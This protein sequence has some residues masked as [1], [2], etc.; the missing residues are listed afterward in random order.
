MAPH[1]T[2]TGKEVRRHIGPLVGIGIVI[3]LVLVGLV[4]WLSTV[5]SGP[6]PSEPSSTVEVPAADAPR[7]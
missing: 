2:N 6:D 4:W 5:F 3:V 1:D 7:N